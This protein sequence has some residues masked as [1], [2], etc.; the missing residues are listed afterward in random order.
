LTGSIA[1]KTGLFTLTF[2]NGSGKA[3]TTGSGAFLQNQAIGGG[4]F[5]GTTNAGS[6]I[7]TPAATNP[8]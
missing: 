8:N 7:I 5:T 6:I 3:T 1:A 4:F 2:G